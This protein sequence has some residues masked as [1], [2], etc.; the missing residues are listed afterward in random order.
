[1]QGDKV[2]PTKIYVK[3]FHIFLLGTFMVLSGLPALIA[4]HFYPE[5]LLTGF[6]ITMLLTTCFFF[7]ITI[8]TRM[9][10]FVFGG[11]PVSKKVK[12]I[13]ALIMALYLALLLCWGWAKKWGLF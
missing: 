3:I 9:V 11:L 10:D 2:M 8:K 12:V 13:A 4:K 7:V 1:M 6:S 5:Y